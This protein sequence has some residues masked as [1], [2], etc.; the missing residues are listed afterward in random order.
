MFRGV[1]WLII[2]AFFLLFLRGLSAQDDVTVQMEPSMGF[3]DVS[4]QFTIVENRSVSPL[5]WG[6]GFNVSY[7]SNPFPF[8]EF[9]VGGEFSYM[10]T[11]SDR[12]FYNNDE[13]LVNSSSLTGLNLLLQYRLFRNYPIGIFPEISA[14]ILA[15]GFSSTFNYY[16]SSTGEDVGK[17]EKLRLFV[18]PN[19]GL[20]LGI[21]FLNYITVKCRYVMSLPVKH[22]HPS[23][24]YEIGT[25]IYYPYVQKPINRFDILLSVSLN[26]IY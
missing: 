15:P 23:E 2:S 4:A 14:G 8:R 11:G 12:I 26:R 25:D 16:D 1:N 24:V 19:L 20:G 17:L 9:Y 18:T 22:F 10:F 7:T 21:K 5:R 6:G 13:Y 3:F